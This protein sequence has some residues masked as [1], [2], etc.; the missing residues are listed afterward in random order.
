MQAV[1]AERV[2]PLQLHVLD[3]LADLAAGG[4]RDGPRER[5]HVEQ[6][7]L[8]FR[9]QAAA[10]EALMQTALVY[11]T[12]ELLVNG[13]WAGADWWRDNT[14]ERQFF[15]T[16][17]RASD[18]FVKA[19]QAAALPDGD[20]LETFVTCVALGFRGVYRGH[21]GPARAAKPT[22]VAAQQASEPA[23]ADAAGPL[24]AWDELLG[25]AAKPEADAA[26]DA[27]GPVA[28]D[29]MA[30]FAEPAAAPQAANTGASGEVDSLYLAGLDL[31][32]TLDGW[33][34]P[35]LVRL[36][37]LTEPDR[38]DPAEPPED[39]RDAAPLTSDDA[40]TFATVVVIVAS[41]CGVG[42]LLFRVLHSG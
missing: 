29:W 30:S 19:Q 34:A 7:L 18:F 41:L 32:P 33:A 31:P 25:D 4:E 11:W 20:A 37:K 28:E 21:G 36:A 27:A 40:L 13:D 6:L 8:Q 42:A 16:R 39:Q 23:A 3:L 2:R 35:L 15:N 17:N 24:A 10:A 12:D 1:N 22:P 14:L 9:P 5:S 38:F 26:S